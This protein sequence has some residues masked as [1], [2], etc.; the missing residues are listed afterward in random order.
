MRGFPLVLRGSSHLM[1]RG[2]YEPQLGWATSIATFRMGRRQPI[3]IWRVTTALLRSCDGLECLGIRAFD[4]GRFICSTV[5]TFPRLQTLVT[6]EWLIS[7][8]QALPRWFVFAHNSAR[9]CRYL[10]NQTS[11]LGRNAFML[12]SPLIVAIPSHCPILSS[13]TA[14]INEAGLTAPRHRYPVF[15]L[16]RPSPTRPDRCDFN[17]KERRAEKSCHANRVHW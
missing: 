12:G 14:R 10:S 4:A 1:H 8:G 11:C 5:V 9:L 13:R 7:E 17:T 15:R 2:P 16:P 6:T 3:Y